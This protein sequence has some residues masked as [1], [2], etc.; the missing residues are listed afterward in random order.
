MGGGRQGLVPNATGTATDP[1][2]PWACS[3]LDG[4]DLIQEYKRD[5]D[6]RKLKYSV[7]S[8]NQEL[9]GV[10]FDDTDYLLG[11]FDKFPLTV[12]MVPIRNFL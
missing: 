5:K 6:S 4:R 10:N 3:R 8:N 9:R 7:V 2:S 1:L 12:Y 11:E